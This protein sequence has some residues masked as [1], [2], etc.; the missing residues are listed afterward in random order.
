MKLV[1]KSRVD[2]CL[3]IL[4]DVP[5]VQLSAMEI[6]AV[7]GEAN[8]GRWETKEYNAVVTLIRNGILSSP[9]IAMA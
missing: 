5:D 7:R 9:A 4:A 1:R 2:E 8:K 6:D 3:V